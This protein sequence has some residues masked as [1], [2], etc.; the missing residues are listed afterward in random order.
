VIL[1]AAI[2]LALFLLPAPWGAFALAVATAVEVAEAAFWIRLSRRRPSVSGAEGLEGALAEVV[3]P[4]R[5][6]GQVR[7]RG[8]LWRARCRAGADPGER[9]IV[10]ALDGLTLVVEPYR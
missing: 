6:E 1:V 2:L 9:V 4:C 8:E 5:P 7:V 10:R 3:T